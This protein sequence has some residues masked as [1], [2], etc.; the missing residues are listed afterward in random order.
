[1]DKACQCRSRGK[2]A[3]DHN[4]LHGPTPS[5]A[6][7][8][9][10]SARLASPY[11]AKVRDPNWLAWDNNEKPC[12]N[13]KGASFPDIETLNGSTTSDF[14]AWRGEACFARGSKHSR[15]DLMTPFVCSEVHCVILLH[16]TGIHM[17]LEYNIFNSFVS[18]ILFLAPSLV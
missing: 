8:L 18:Q 5:S 11:L 13:R 6:R 10:S 9:G 1:M 3:A 4:A 2:I 15:N 16:L 17:I 14:L 7:R 12:Q